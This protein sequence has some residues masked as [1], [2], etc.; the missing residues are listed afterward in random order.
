MDQAGRIKTGGS[1]GFSFI[2][3][4][5]FLLGFYALASQSILLRELLVVVLGNEVIFGIS[6]AHWLLAVFVGAWTGGRAAER[7]RRPI[8][9]LSLSL[10]TMCLLPPL[11]ITLIRNLYP[12]SQTPAGTYIPFFK[13]FVFSGLFIVPFA[14]FIGFTFPLAARLQVS[15][16]QKPGRQP[17]RQNPVVHVADVYIVESVGALLGGVIFSFLLAGKANPYFWEALLALPLLLIVGLMNVKLRQLLVFSLVLILLVLDILVLTPYGHARLDHITV[18][19]RW[20][21]FS[22]SDLVFSTDSRYQ[23]IALGEMGGQ[24]NLYTN[25]QLAGI[26]PEENDNLILAAHLLCQHPAPKR[27]LI[28]GEALTGLGKHLLKYN[29]ETLISVEIDPQ[30]V[31]TIRTYLPPSYR[32]VMADKRF[33]SRLEDG[34]KFVKSLITEG[35]DRHGFDLVFIDRP[36]PASLLSNRYYTLDFFRDVGQVLSPDG[37]LALRITSSENYT[38][39]IVSDYT[40]SIYR[41]L[42]TVFPFIA[43]SPGETNFFFCSQRAGIVTDSPAVLARRYEETGVSPKRLGLIFQSIYPTEKT[44]FIKNSLEQHPLEVVNSDELPLSTFYYNKILGWTSFEGGGLLFEISEVLTLKNI[45]IFMGVLLL[46]RL[47]WMFRQRRRQERFYSLDIPVCVMTGGFA[48]MAL[49][50]L[51]ITAFQNIFGYV[52]QFIG[53]LIALFMAGLPLGA[54]FSRRM[55]ER[56]DDRRKAQTVILILIQ[57]GLALISVLFPYL[58]RVFAFASPWSQVLLFGLTVLIGGL[59]GAIFPLSLNLYLADGS[60]IGRAAGR[61]DAADHFGAALGALFCGALLLPLLGLRNITYL[62]AA[63]SAASAL[64]LLISMALGRGQKGEHHG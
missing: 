38:A 30:Y 22:G 42:K 4:V 44:G 28:I 56:G 51:I 46:I 8:I 48:G 18:R 10:M 25:G 24:Y 61:I 2:L 32:Q 62:L 19:Q 64:L 60:A 15:R 36:E 40:A 11:L 47:V 17:R 39:G 3:A 21:S 1:K 6:L 9:V 59:V 54:F 16:R 13:V 43:I 20:R 53:F 35:T 29:I 52:Y 34:R 49:E 41:T 31:R 26:F 50:L 37:V 7:S 14:F 58:I 5:Y 12:L 23:N 55:I 57:L 27:I 63:F 45:F 33:S